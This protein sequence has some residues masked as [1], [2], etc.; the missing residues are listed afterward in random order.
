MNKRRRAY[1]V[2]SS[3]WDRE[4]H[5]PFQDFRYRL[6]RMM[7]QVL[8]G[9]ADGRLTGPY[10]TDGQAIVLED[11]LEIRPERRGQIEQFL[12]EGRLASGPWYVLPDEFL[13]SGES[14]IRNLR[15]GRELV[16][17]LGGTPSSA[18]ILADLFGH[19]ASTSGSSR[20]P[21]CTWAR[22]SASV[23][24]RLPSSLPPSSAGP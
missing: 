12:R 11:Y 15:A 2:L 4:W 13:V 10:T 9:L 22:R 1:Y 7:D 24:G 23:N 6:V 5:Q 19:S 17:S 14:L 16:R 3:H 20:R 8:D 18:G 21:Y